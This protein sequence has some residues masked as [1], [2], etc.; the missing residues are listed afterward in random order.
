MKTVTSIEQIISDWAAKLVATR[1]GE[2]ASYRFVVTGHEG[3]SWVVDLGRAVFERSEGATDCTVEIDQENLR[4]LASG[5]L[6]PQRAYLQGTLRFS[7]PSEL[8]LALH[9]LF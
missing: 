4:A 8:G 3:G 6:N 7:G 5:Q 9:K 1:T 2:T